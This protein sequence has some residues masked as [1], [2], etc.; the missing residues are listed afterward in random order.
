MRSCRGGRCV[1]ADVL[2]IFAQAVRNARCPRCAARALGLGL[3]CRWLEEV[4]P[5]MARGRWCAAVCRWLWQA[6]LLLARG[7]DAGAV[8]QVSHYNCQQV[9]AGAWQVRMGIEEAHL[10]CTS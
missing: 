4:P 5:G 10:R 2:G 1:H 6:V 8:Q 7:R 9:E 3:V